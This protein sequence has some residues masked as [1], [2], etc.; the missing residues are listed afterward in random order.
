[1]DKHIRLIT[2]CVLILSYSVVGRFFQTEDKEKSSVPIKRIENI[3]LSFT[4]LE[5]NQDHMSEQIDEAVEGS[6]DNL[7]M[8]TGLEVEFAFNLERTSENPLR[9][10]YTNYDWGDPVNDFPDSIEFAYIPLSDLMSGP[11][12]FTFDTGLEPSLIAAESRSHQLV[13][14]PYVDYPS[15][16]S[17]LPDFLSE[18]V[19][20]Q[21][22]TVHGGGLSPDY[23]DP[24]LQAALLSFIKSLGQRYDGDPRLAVIQLGLL[25]F[26]GEWHTWPHDKWFPN[27]DFQSKVINSYVKSFAI[28]LLQVRRPV[29]NTPNL[30]IGFHDDSFAYSTLGDFDWYFHPSLIEAGADDRWREVSIGGELRPELQNIIF[31]N[32][33]KNNI[34]QSFERCVRTTHISMLLNYSIYSGGLDSLEE[35]DRAEA[36]AL[37][38][39]YVIHVSKVKLINK[40]LVVT[41]ENRGVA[42]FYPSL[43]LQVEDISG[44]NTRVKLTRITTDQGPKK[45]YLNVCRLNPPGHQSPWT[46]SLQSDYILP[47]QKILFATEPGQGLIRVE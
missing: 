5:D 42:P 17:G 8:S 18:K 47:S 37:S 10:F 23:N 36:A 12:S 44:I 43:F 41:L 34:G 4:N 25:G 7:S 35:R 33:Y 16:K 26:W 46:L 14:R 30:R 2:S 40:V 45:F 38:L 15:L 24:D 11:S 31:E 39:G 27:D 22:Y 13:L 1:M 9:G 19:Q 28:T 6:K 21:P 3:N 32:N 29:A 20:M